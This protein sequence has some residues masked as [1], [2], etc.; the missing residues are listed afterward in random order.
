MQVGDRAGSSDPCCYDNG[1]GCWAA[2]DMSVVCTVCV[3]SA[4]QSGYSVLGFHSLNW[5][6]GSGM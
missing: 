5:I 2:T 1:K 6:Q 4:G 3:H